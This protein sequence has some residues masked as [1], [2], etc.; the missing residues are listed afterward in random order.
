MNDKTKVALALGLLSTLGL[1][2]VISNA[3]AQQF[4]PQVA[5]IDRHSQNSIGEGNDEANNTTKPS[6]NVQKLA[7]KNK[8]EMSDGDGEENDE[9]EDARLQSLAKITPQEAK[10]IAEDKVGGTAD[11]VQLENEGG[12]LVYAIDIGKKEVLVDAGNGKILQ[13]QN[14]NESDDDRVAPTYHSSI[15]VPDNDAETNDDGGR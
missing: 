11:K 4:Q 3:Y 13:V 8:N 15:Q 14:D 7:L 12:N 10:K 2:F 6:E 9:R 1:G 5:V